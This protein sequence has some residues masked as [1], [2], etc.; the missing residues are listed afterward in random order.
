M[1]AVKLQIVLQCMER[2]Y[3]SSLSS[4]SEKGVMFL[5]RAIVTYVSN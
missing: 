3:V 2:I 1:L 4:K 5:C